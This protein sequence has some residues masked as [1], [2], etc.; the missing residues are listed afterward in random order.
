MATPPE[1]Y[2]QEVDEKY[3][4]HRLE[5]ADTQLTIASETTL[6]LLCRQRIIQAEDV[7]RAALAAER[8]AFEL[9]CLLARR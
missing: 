9:R 7:E 2:V 8:A 5:D 6:D 3:I 1:P 4:D